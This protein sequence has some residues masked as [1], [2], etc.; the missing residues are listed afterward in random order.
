MVEEQEKPVE[1]EVVE[2]TPETVEEKVEDI[3]EEA[4]EEA[5]E[6]PVEAPVEEVAEEA[7]EEPAV[8]EPVVD[9]AVEEESLSE[10]ESETL[11]KD[12]EATKEELAVIKEVREELVSLYGKYQTSVKSIEQLS[13]KTDMLTKE[14]ETL[15][16]Q[17][18]RY[19]EAE[20][21]F[22]TKMRIE[23]LNKLSN[24][25]TLLGQKK[26]VEHLGAMDDKTLAEFETIVDAAIG[27]A[28]ET[29]EMLSETEPSNVTVEDSA[30]ERKDEPKPAKVEEKKE[31]LSS[32]AFF[33]G[34][35]GELTKEQI[36]KARTARHM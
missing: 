14:N 31:A 15:A 18:L 12:I 16:T 34:L 36:G 32:K 35:C 10:D 4:T 33:A 28:G 1:E 21:E 6:A 5:V 19:V 23:R 29:K 27:K 3:A 25:F 24:K 9:E 26:T 11:N 30:S 8:E 7:V 2:T 17:L 13:K 22:N 20:A